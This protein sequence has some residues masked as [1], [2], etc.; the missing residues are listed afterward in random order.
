MRSTWATRRSVVKK[1]N[2]VKD[3]K[4]DLTNTRMF[5]ECFILCAVTAVAI[6]T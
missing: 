5:Q 3:S 4:G 6:Y 1:G 2:L